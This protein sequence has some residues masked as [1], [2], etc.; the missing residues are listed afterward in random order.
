MS[1]SLPLRA[2][3]EWLKKAAKEQLEQLRES[4]ADAQLSDA[5][6]VVAREY[7]FTSWRELKA[8]VDQ[9]QQVTEQFKTLQA[10][11]QASPPETIQPDDP[12]LLSVMAAIRQGDQKTLEQV[13]TRRPGLAK[14]RDADGQTPLHLAAENNDPVMGVALL[15]FGADSQAKYG[16]SGH[17]PLSWAVTCHA[18][19]FAQTL[20]R[21]G[22]KPDLFTAA[23]MGSLDAVRLC[24][25][26][27]G[28]LRSGMAQTGS[29]RF[30]S[31]GTRLPCPPESVPEQI[32][33][34]LYMACRNGQ[35]EIARFLLTKHPDLSF[36]GYL[37]GTLLHWACFGCNNEVIQLIEQKGGDYSTRDDSLHCTPR[38][39]GICVPANWGFIELVERQ[40]KRDPTLASFMDGQTSALHEGAKAGHLKIVQLLVNAGTDRTMKNGDGK[41][42]LELAQEQGHTQVAELLLER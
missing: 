6:L 39:F 11:T 15:L 36:R 24:F 23:G 29:T 13:L 20:V 37:G 1:K 7:G 17:T 12:D 5:Q 40:L 32:A 27:Q 8:R 9:M 4:Q 10:A 42:A 26:E 14:A 22:V 18:L 38:A 25:D 30:N 19:E 41:T 16:Q 3:L 35:L 31:E 34:A 21:A 2:N 28:N 33:D